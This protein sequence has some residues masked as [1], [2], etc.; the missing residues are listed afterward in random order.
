MLASVSKLVG[1]L[2]QVTGFDDYEVK[3]PRAARKADEHT[4]LAVLRFH[5]LYFAGGIL[6]LPLMFIFSFSRA[7]IPVAI[8]WVLILIGVTRRIIA[9]VDAYCEDKGIDI[10][11]SRYE[12]VRFALEHS[13]DKEGKEPETWL[14]AHRGIDEV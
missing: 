7:I 1:K 6:V 4:N 13:A 9:N 8:I 10:E 5:S 2:K 12:K 14:M 3:A 11:M